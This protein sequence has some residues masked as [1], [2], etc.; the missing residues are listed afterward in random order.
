MTRLEYIRTRI[1]R[2]PGLAIAGSY[3]NGV[4][5]PDT[6]ESGLRAAAELQPD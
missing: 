4:G 1:A 6:F 2:L 5:V 3:L